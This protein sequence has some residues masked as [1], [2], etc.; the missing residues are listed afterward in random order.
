MFRMIKYADS[1]ERG[2]KATTDAFAPNRALPERWR[3]RRCASTTAHRHAT[4]VRPMFAPGVDTRE[5]VS[6]AFIRS[7]CLA[8][9]PFTGDNDSEREHERET[10][11]GHASPSEFQEAGIMVREDEE[12]GGDDN[13]FW[14]AEMA[15]P[16]R[17]RVS[18]SRVV[19]WGCSRNYEVVAR[20]RWS[21]RCASHVTL[22]PPLER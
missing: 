11:D 3:S 6:I 7:V 9:F 21:V 5:Q 19:L 12:D 4:R 10:A 2:R 17:L 22:Y 14:D 1:G 13:L 20:R 16:R 18:Y 15:L 8:R